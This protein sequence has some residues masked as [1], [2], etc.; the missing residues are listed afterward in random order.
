ML[1]DVSVLD[2]SSESYWTSNWKIYWP[3]NNEVYFYLTIDFITNF[4]YNYSVHQPRPHLVDRGG[5][6]GGGVVRL[7]SDIPRNKT[8]YRLITHGL[9]VRHIC[10]FSDYNTYV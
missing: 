7:C 5:R 6:G 10:I 3:G 8:L 9:T 4:V 1:H 2:L